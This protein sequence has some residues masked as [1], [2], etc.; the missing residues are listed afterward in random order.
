MQ[1]QEPAVRNIELQNVDVAP[2]AVDTKGWLLLNADIRTELEG[3]VDNLYNFKYDKAERQFRS[4]RRRYPAHPLPYFLLGLSTWWKILP[5]NVTV[6]QFDKPF[7]AYI[8]TAVTKAQALYDQD[9]H[10]YEAC[11]FLS[12]AYGFSSRLHA[13]RHDWTRAT[14]E[15]KRALK[16]L[17]LSKE[18]NGL[19]P[20]FLFGQALFNYYSVW[21]A[22]E[23][24]WLKPVL[25]LFP[26]GDKPLGLQQLRNVAANAVYTGPES[27]FFLLKILGSQRENRT[28]EALEV[29]RK[30]VQEFPD[31][32]YFQRLYALQCF[33]EGDFAACEKTS[34]AILDKYN[35]GLPGY[36]GF[37]G[38]YASYFLGYIRQNMYK[39]KDL[40][41][42]KSY[43]Q[44]CIVFSET[45]EQTSGGYYLFSNLNLARLA[46]AEKDLPSA[47][48]YYKSVLAVAD[49][50]SPN[51]QEAKKY[52]KSLKKRA[53]TTRDRDRVLLVQQRQ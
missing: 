40:T 42:A 30:L 31:N 49:R 26:K 18:A 5:T 50:K 15:A 17:E 3:G 48:R 34:L 46:A 11:F 39:D 19:S 32:A 9:S 8:D 21:I 2:S 35:R 23:H 24:P 52:L 38:R 22:E 4:L 53:G 51:Y 1:A 45:T 41:R 10:N 44:R 16:Y 47:S 25:L 33:N 6:Q 7:F 27:R 14:I 28:A 43:Y 12:A 29:A 36:D 37:S 13:E 20:E